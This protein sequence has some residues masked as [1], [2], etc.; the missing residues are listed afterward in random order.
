[1]STSDQRKNN[2][3]HK[4]ESAELR[5]LLL[6]KEI[7]T[8]IQNIILKKKRDNREDTISIEGQIIISFV[9]GVICGPYTYSIIL[10]ILFF[11]LYEII[12]FVIYRRWPIKLRISI[13]IA[14]IIGVFI[15]C[16]CVG[17]QDPKFFY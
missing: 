7:T 4:D 14:Y 2:R 3:K 17:S 8:D 12:F 1:M 16:Y 10:L 11:I 15:G 13:I 9:L 6:T 5:R